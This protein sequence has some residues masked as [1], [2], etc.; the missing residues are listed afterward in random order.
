MAEEVKVSKLGNTRKN[1]VKF[2]KEVRSELK[3]V[4]WP[5]R[6]QL[7]NN[8]VTVLACC[9]IVGAIIWVVDWGLTSIIKTFLTKS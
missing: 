1:F 3:K 7:R 6:V 4:I 5:S 8:T 9:F 2:F